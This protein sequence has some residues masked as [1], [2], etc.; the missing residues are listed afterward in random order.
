MNIKLDINLSSFKQMEYFSMVKW[1]KLENLSI[2]TDEDT[3][4]IQNIENKFDFPL[5]KELYLGLHSSTFYF[6]E[7]KNNLRTNHQQD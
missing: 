4:D 3:L 1:K 7:R 5:L 2:H 6:Y